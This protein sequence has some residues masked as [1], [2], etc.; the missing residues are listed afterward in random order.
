MGEAVADLRAWMPVM[1]YCPVPVMTAFSRTFVA[2][3]GA[4]EGPPV[5][6]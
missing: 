4:L 6:A 5:S 2:F 1:G 3:V